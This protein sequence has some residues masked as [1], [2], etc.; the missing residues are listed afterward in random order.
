MSRTF[1]RFT[2]GCWLLTA[3][4]V[5]AC[6]PEP[7]PTPALPTLAP[8]PTLTLTPTLTPTPSLTP[9]PSPTP[10]PIPS[11]NISDPQQQTFVRVVHTIPEAPAVDV[12]IEGLSVAGFLAY[13]QFT[14]RVGVEAGT[15]TVR[16]YESGDQLGVDTPLITQSLSFEGG[17]DGLLLVT[18][19]VTEPLLAL[20]NEALEPLERGQSRVSFI[21]AVVRGP[22]FVA[23][24]L[25]ETLSAPLTFGQQSEPVTFASG[26]AEITLDS[27]DNRL[28]TLADEFDERESTTYIL[29]GR[30]DD[31]SNLALLRIDERVPGQTRVRVVHAVR[32]LSSLVVMANRTFITDN[33]NYRDVSERRSLVEGVYEM[34]VYDGGVD[35]ATR[36]PV[37]STQFIA[38]ARSDTTLIVV[39]SQDDLRLVTV[40]ENDEPTPQERARITFVNARD[41]VRQARLD[42]N[43]EAYQDRRVFFAQATPPELYGLNQFGLRWY[44]PDVPE[45]QDD[46]AEDPDVLA[47][48]QASGPEAA[49]LESVDGLSINEGQAYIYVFTASRDEAPL[50]LSDDVGTNNLRIDPI[51]GQAQPTATPL[52][53]ARVRVINAVPGLF[54]NVQ[55]NDTPFSNRLAYQ[56]STEFIIIPSQENTFSV[57]DAADNRLLARERDVY[58]PGSLQ[59]LIL[60]GDLEA[61]SVRLLRVNDAPVRDLVV[62][63]VNASLRL[64]NVSLPRNSFLGVTFIAMDVEID[65]ITAEEGYRRSIPF[66]LSTA[67]QDVDSR[68]ASSVVRVPA[69]EIALQVVDTAQNDLALVLPTFEFEANAHYDVIAFEQEAEGPDGPVQAFVLPF[70]A[71]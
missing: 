64:I 15:Y 56:N 31:L 38:N 57:I 20:R 2:M 71:P 33:L 27:G 8:T 1:A 67:V 44:G 58:E 13:R 60:Y 52:P 50:V 10:F 41:D 66:G 22:D 4:V 34:E 5:S 36:E 37:L 7:A 48:A 42:F 14:G 43:S 17:Q 32:D 62:D 59:T 9:R 23:T 61:N 68:T 70:V 29:T 54:A 47:T 55:L 40:R 25:G 3:L 28:L 51:T 53:P 35:P 26:Q 46:D 19:S 65:P 63:N 45:P 49:L 6:A 39:G 21:H 16:A 69:G 18:G 24:R 11:T 30:N 12:Y